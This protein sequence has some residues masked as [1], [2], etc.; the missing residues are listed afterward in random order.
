MWRPII[1]LSAL[2]VI[3]KKGLEMKILKVNMRRGKL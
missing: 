2:L 3:F 1:T